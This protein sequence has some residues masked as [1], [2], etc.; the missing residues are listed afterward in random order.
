MEKHDEYD[1]QAHKLASI[2]ADVAEFYV[3]FHHVSLGDGM[4]FI[5]SLKSQARQM[6]VTIYNNNPVQ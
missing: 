5:N 4:R 3:L 6:D 1:R 2:A